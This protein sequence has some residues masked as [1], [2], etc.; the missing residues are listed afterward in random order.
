MSI[1]QMAHYADV[2]TRGRTPS[3]LEIAELAVQDSSDRARA[4]IAYMAL[5]L[6]NS[7][8]TYEE[9]MA[10]LAPLCPMMMK[11]AMVA[12]C[13]SPPVQLCESQ[14]SVDL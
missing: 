1:W 5:S 11:F 2:E 14:P 9:L 8:Y 7:N 3:L 4:N 6:V 13:G 10:A 12:L